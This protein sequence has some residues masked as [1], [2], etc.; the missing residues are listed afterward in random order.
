MNEPKHI[1]VVSPHPDDESIG[2]GGTL[3]AHVV[4]GDVVHAVFLTS[5]EQGGHGRTPDQT[6]ALRE[7]EARDAAAILGLAQIEFW[8]EPDG[9]LNASSSLV[10]KLRATLRKFRPAL[11]LVPHD[12]EMHPDHKAAARLVRRAVRRIVPVP[13]VWMFEV[14]T[15]VQRIDQIIDIS[16]HMT[17][18]LQA[19][20][21]HRS[22]CEAMSFDDAAAGLAR[23]RGEMHLWP[24]GDYAEAFTEW[25]PEAAAA[26]PAAQAG[27]A[28]S[29]KGACS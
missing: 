24:G 3:R 28:A 26:A 12:R 15:P 5:G 7:Q 27:A 14:W 22:Q 1:L 11:I 18:K 19:I 8:R 25:R 23:Y 16:E 4:A 13:E 6:A 21:A 17:V 10:R 9:M 2:C 29:A 20:R